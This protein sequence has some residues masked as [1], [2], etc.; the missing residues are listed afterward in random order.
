MNLQYK[1]D[2]WSFYQANRNDIERIICHV[3]KQYVSDAV[4]PEDLRSEILLR[5]AQSNFLSTYTPAIA[6]L[7]S[8]L[9]S[10]ARGYARHAI[11]DQTPVWQQILVHDLNEIPEGVESEETLTDSTDNKAEYRLFACEILKAL[12]RKL[13]ILLY[14]RLQG[15]KDID[16]AAKLNVTRPLVS[17]RAADMKR[18]VL[19]L[20][21][22][23]Y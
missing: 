21:K 19:K 7:N 6:T 1:K 13:R 14:W 16:I 20:L 2:F 15:L 8:Y 5:L 12:P 11:R 4:P 18:A 22:K 3:C 17:F 10:M 9:S 23:G